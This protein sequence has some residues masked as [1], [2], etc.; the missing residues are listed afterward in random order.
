MKIFA[1]F[2]Q[3][4]VRC[5]FL[6]KKLQDWKYP[7]LHKRHH[8]RFL[9]LIFYRTS[10]SSCFCKKQ[11]KMLI[12]LQ[13]QKQLQTQLKLKKVTACTKI[14]TPAVNYLFK[15]NNRNTRTMC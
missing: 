7:T 1:K 11:Q 2:T 6:S 13:T 5:C 4:Y 3:K 15:S 8:R 12:K 9:Q 14:N 10:G